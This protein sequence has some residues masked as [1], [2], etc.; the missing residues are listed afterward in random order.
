ML[1]YVHRNHQAYLGRGVQDGY[2]DFHTAPEFCP[3]CLFVRFNAAL[4]PQKSSGLSGT[5]SPGRLPRLTQLL[6][7]ALPICSFQCCFTSLETIRLSRDG[8]SRTATSTLSHSFLSSALP[9]RLFLCFN[10]ALRPQKP[11][12]LIGTGSPGRPPRLSH[13]S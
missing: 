11:S 9:V 12:G 4:R 13:S 6:S 3:S 8:E 10:V 1:L 2:L 5:G 7:S